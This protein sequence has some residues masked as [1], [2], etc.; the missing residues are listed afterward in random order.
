MEHL[1]PYCKGLWKL[2]LSVQNRP[3]FLHEIGAQSSC[4]E[5]EVRPKTG[6]IH[7]FVRLGA[8]IRAVSDHSRPLDQFL[9]CACL[10]VRSG[11]S[12]LGGGSRSVCI[13]VR[14]TV[15]TSVARLTT[16]AAT[17]CGRF[18]LEASFLHTCLVLLCY[19][20]GDPQKG[21]PESCRSRIR[22]IVCRSVAMDHGLCRSTRT[23]RT[24][25]AEFG[26]HF[27]DG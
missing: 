13:A 11:S 3:I 1:V 16:A 8:R 10:A 19:K 24:P 20:K 6:A 9:P 21:Q 12:L 25:R 4:R 22:A 14:L 18:D 5:K 2:A 7:P 17:A 26:R 23:G 27:G 15:G